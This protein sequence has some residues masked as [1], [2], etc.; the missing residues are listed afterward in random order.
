MVL[1][2][3]AFRVTTTKSA[4]TEM[5]CLGTHRQDVLVTHR[6]DERGHGVQGAGGCHVGL[7]CP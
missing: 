2:G 5:W 3:P 7:G 1:K 6:S 4:T